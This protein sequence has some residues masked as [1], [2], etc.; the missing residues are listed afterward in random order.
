MVEKKF[1]SN[2]C[3]YEVAEMLKISVRTLSLYL[4]KMYYDELQKLGYYKN[5]KKLT[6]IQLNWLSKKIDL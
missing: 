6:P 3:K 2:L 5:Q 4:N 1:T